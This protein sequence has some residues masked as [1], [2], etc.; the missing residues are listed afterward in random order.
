MNLFSLIK[1]VIN[2]KKTF[3]FLPIISLFSF[4]LI[5]TY[6]EDRT[7][8]LQSSSKTYWR[9]E[10]SNNS[11]KYMNSNVS[12][13]DLIINGERYL[14]SL[15]NLKLDKHPSVSGSGIPKLLYYETESPSFF[16]K[17]INSLIF[18][19]SLINEMTW[20]LSKNILWDNYYNYDLYLE[21]TIGILNNNLNGVDENIM[22]K[23]QEIL[24]Q[25]D[26]IKMSYKEMTNN[27]FQIYFDALVDILK[28][29]PQII[30]QYEEF[31]KKNN[32]KFFFKSIY[33]FKLNDDYSPIKIKKIY[34]Q[35]KPH[36]KSNKYLISIAGFLAGIILA[37]IITTSYAL[38][39]ARNK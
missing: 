20:R 7:D 33:D 1:H 5:F 23:R 38:N 9:F 10:F 8:L 36:L 3:I 14:A 26:H 6:I 21:Y 27:Y 37:F 18:E 24:F 22:K 11:S 12:F 19:N 30:N 32:H 2:F 39:T 25:F 13:D 35:D 15:V 17:H 4:I 31:L 34:E 29:Q 16:S 28:D